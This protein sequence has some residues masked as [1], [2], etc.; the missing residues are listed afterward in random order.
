M[1]HCTKGV[2]F[3]ALHYAAWY[4]PLKRHNGLGYKLVS[5]ALPHLNINIHRAAQKYSECAVF[6]FSLRSKIKIP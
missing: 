2:P 6:I 3:P 5:G 4:S 1:L